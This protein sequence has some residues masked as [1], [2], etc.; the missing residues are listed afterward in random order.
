VSE[1]EEKLQR[2][3]AMLALQQ[4]DALLLTRNANLAWFT[5]GAR[6]FVN[7]ATDAGAA[8]ILVTPDRHFLLTNNIEATRLDAEERL[9]DLGFELRVSFWYEDGSTLVDLTRGMR[10][11]A[12]APA[13]GAADVSQAMAELRLD[14]SPVEQDRFRKLARLCAKAMDGAI[15]RVRPGMTEFEIAGLLAQETLDRGVL[16]IVNLIATDE[17][18]FRFRHP[19]PTTRVLERYAMLVLCGRQSGLVASITRLVHFGPL[20][21]ELQAK[22]EACARVDAAFIH[23][24]RPGRSLADVL[25][26]GVAAYGGTGYPGEWQLHHQGGPAG[27]EPREIVATPQAVDQLV[28]AGQVYAWNPSIAGVKSEDTFLVGGQGNAILTQI[29][30]W[31]AIEVELEGSVYLRPAILIA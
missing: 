20:P 19:L 5:G 13:L 15:R 18:I 22:Q 30:G 14:L 17:R 31:P 4:L 29:S 24:T 26:A 6:F 7:T 2:V 11:G 12:D 1:V 8:S 23:N 25:A 16:P 10:L 9:A 27:Y 21:E 28:R 3:R